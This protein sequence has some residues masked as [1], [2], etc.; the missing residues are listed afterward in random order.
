MEQEYE[1]PAV[2]LPIR[3]LVEF[4]LRTGSIDNRFSGFDRANEGA[5]I[6][7]RLQRAALKE[8]PDYTAETAL[9]QTF[10]CEGIEYTLEGRADGIFTASDR[11]VTVEEIK[12]TTRP[13]SEITEDFA[14]EHWAQ[15]MVYADIL[16]IQKDFPAVRVELVYFQVDEE[17]V[18]RFSRDFTAAALDEFVRDLLTRYA[19]WARR[20]AQWKAESRASLR[21]LSFPFEDYRPGQRA[22]AGEVYR[23]CRDG[24]QLLC[25]APTGIGKTMSVLFPALK[26]MADSAQGPIFY[27]TAR[28]TTRIAAENALSLLRSHDEALKLRSITLTAKDKICLCEARECTPDA[29][30]YA[31]GYYARIKDALWDAL[32]APALTAEVLQEYARK[33]NVCPFELGLDLSLWCDVIVGDYNYLFDP[34]VRLSRFFESRGDYLFLIDEAHNLP[35]RAREMHSASLCKS[36]FYDARKLLGKGKSRL[37]Q[38]LTRINDLWIEWRHKAEELPSGNERSGRTFFLK[39]RC[40]AFDRALT[41]LCEPLTEWLEEHREPSEIHSALLEFYFDVRAWLRVADSFDEHFV[42][43]ITASG[44]EVRAVQLCLDP[45][46]FLARDFSLGRAAVLFSATLAP[47]G[48]YRDLCGIPDARAVALRSPFPPE[49]MGLLCVRNISTRYR[50]RETSIDPIAD[51]LAAMV[52]AQKGNY[53]AFFPSYAY[54][55]QVFARFTEKYPDLSVIRQETDMDEAQRESF[56]AQFTPDTPEGLLGFA[57]LGGV[58]GEGVD[59]TGSSLIGA[60]IIGPGLPQVGPRQEQLREYFEQTRGAGFDYAYR[61]P[62]MNKVL[63]AAGRVI[64]TPQDKGVV[65]LID[66][67]FAMPDYL[68]LMPPHWSHL[69]LVQGCDSLEQVL[70]EFWAQN[71]DSGKIE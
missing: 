57:V 31:N 5:R 26:A 1:L 71:S 61:F 36:Q 53:L 69:R 6:H 62:G 30:P 22:M 11:S 55:D 66:D 60:A 39:E 3:Q 16:A 67:R 42:L 37:R 54:L 2:T 10:H 14:P 50:D 4:L 65:L 17:S 46:G 28:G 70:K 45:S 32:D 35:G 59:L 49:H 63:Q 34:V 68:R 24:G 58:F 52:K 23:V 48:Y 20:A 7:R 44:R 12:T 38:A 8:H 40:D 56:L 64:R 51:T 18:I 43:Q 41:H 27:L 25:Q 47:A 15:G 21:A 19:P 9:R 13:L 33:Y 29:C